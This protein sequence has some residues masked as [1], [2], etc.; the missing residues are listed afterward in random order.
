MLLEIIT[1]DVQAASAGAFEQVFYAGQDHLQQM[2]DY[3]TH[4]LQGSVDHPGHY[5]LLIEWQQLPERPSHLS[6]AWWQDLQR[7]TVD[8][9]AMRRYR[10]VA[11]RGVHTPPQRVPGFID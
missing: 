4:E 10:M 5:V 11:G 7:F 1:L 6:T 8:A 9:P 2:P 3:L